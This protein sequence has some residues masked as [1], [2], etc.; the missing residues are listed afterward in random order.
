MR[1][2]AEQAGS[3]PDQDLPG[4]PRPTDPAPLPPAEDEDNGGETH[5]GID[6]EGKFH[7]LPHSLAQR[8]GIS[9]DLEDVKVVDPRFARYSH[10][11]L[12]QAGLAVVAMLVIL[13][14]VNS[15]SDAALAAGLGSSLVILF[16]HPSSNAAKPRSLIGGHGFGL[17]AGVGA[18]LIFLSPIGE[19]IEQT[20]VLFDLTLA[21]SVGVLILIMAITDTEH[22]PAAGTVLGVA[23]QP[24]DPIRVAVIIGAVMLLALIKWLL[25]TRLRDLI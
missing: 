23:M 21:V 8:L 15:L 7:Y 25:Q 9:E 22:P 19:F 24:W 5:F 10:S 11:Y 17:L 12:A 14:F 1:D 20:R 16:V 6:S 4:R 3:E 13:L 2:N 18:L